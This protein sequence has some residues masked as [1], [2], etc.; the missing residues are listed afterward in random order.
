M[1]KASSAGYSFLLEVELG[2]NVIHMKSDM[3]P[4]GCHDVLYIKVN[5]MH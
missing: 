3:K 5:S 4:P 2:H 1:T